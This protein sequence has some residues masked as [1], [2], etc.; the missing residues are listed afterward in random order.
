MPGKDIFHLIADL[1]RTIGCAR[2]TTRT[3]ANNQEK[4]LVIVQREALQDLRV[5]QQELGKAQQEFE[6]VNGGPRWHWTH[7][8]PTINYY[9]YEKTQ[10]MYKAKDSRKHVSHINTI[11]HFH[12]SFDLRSQKPERTKRT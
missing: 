11:K 2:R 7:Q 4:A 6:T 10:K 9:E 3:T 5:S 12:R 1:T 8:S